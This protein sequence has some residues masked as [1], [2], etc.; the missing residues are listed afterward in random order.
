MTEKEKLYPG[1]LLQPSEAD[2]I[3]TEQEKRLLQALFDWQDRSA[4]CH[5]V[6]GE[7]FYG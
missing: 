2:L 5:W 1:I 7:P 6:L 4:K 3:P